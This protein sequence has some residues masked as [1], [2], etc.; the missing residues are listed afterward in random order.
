MGH[1]VKLHYSLYFIK[2]H[3]GHI[4]H[5]FFAK[6]NNLKK[7]TRKITHFNRNTSSL[8][9]PINPIK[10]FLS[11]HCLH[12]CFSLLTSQGCTLLSSQ[13]YTFSSFISDNW[14]TNILK[15][16]RYQYINVFF[17]SIPKLASFLHTILRKKLSF[18]PSCVQFEENSFKLLRIRRT[19]VQN[20]THLSFSHL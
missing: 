9:D 19:I 3:F 5:Q 13:G 16:S 6:R 2:R 17:F 18:N 20:G 14:C 12:C 4:L 1:R 10:D 11:L 8:T 15:I 7:T